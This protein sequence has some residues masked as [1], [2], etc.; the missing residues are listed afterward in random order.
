MENKDKV[1]FNIGDLVR[2][3]STFSARLSHPKETPQSL[4]FGVVIEK[5]TKLHTLIDDE[6]PIYE[7]RIETDYFDSSNK[8]KSIKHTIQTKICRV[9]WLNTKKYAW[10]Y[11][12][13]IESAWS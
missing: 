8:K 1:D 13:D 4:G 12:S 10:E 7:Y 9:Y 2:L 5:L 6:L 3:K 11:E